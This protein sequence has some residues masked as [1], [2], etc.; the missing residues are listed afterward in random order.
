MYEYLHEFI[1]IL[2][3]HI[4]WGKSSC[5]VVS[6]CNTVILVLL[7]LII[8]LFSMWTTVHLLLPHLI[9]LHACM[10]VCIYTY[11]YMCMCICVSVC[12]C[13]YIYIYIKSLWLKLKDG[14]R[15]SLQKFSHHQSDLPETVMNPVSPRPTNE[16]IQHF[17]RHF[18]GSLQLWSLITEFNTM[19]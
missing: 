14:L 12:V 3:L 16:L 1:W 6:T 8:I 15:K 11:T 10:G 4:G 5:K 2:L 7:L 19:M 17:V 9:Y 18:R 13:V